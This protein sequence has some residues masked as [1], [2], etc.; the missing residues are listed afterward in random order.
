MFALI[1]NEF[2]KTWRSRRLVF[3]VFF[4]LLILISAGLYTFYVV[5][6]HRWAPPAQ[7]PWQATVRDQIQSERITVANLQHIKQQSGG[8]GRVAANNGPFARSEAESIDSGIK[9]AQQAISD[10]QYLLDNDVAPVQSNALAASTLFVLGSIIMFLLIRIFGWLASEMIAGERSDRT[11]AILL[12]RPAS[13]D[14]VLFAKTVSMFAVAL[15]V[16]VLTQLLAYGVFAFFL[17]SAGPPGG[18]IGLAIDGAKPLGPG[19]LV[20]M[21]AV[22]FTVM[23]LGAS[24]LAILAVEAMSL[25]ISVLTTRWAAIGITLAVLFAGPVVSGIVAIVIF[26]ITGSQSSSDFLNYVFFNLLNPVGSVAPAL[27]NAPSA[28][29]EGMGVMTHEVLA[30]AGWTVAFFVAAWALF[31]RR[32]E[33]G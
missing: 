22:V 21:P 10:N 25:L 7:T 24:M 19:N 8:S 1:S 5:R 12:S 20:Q 11:I 30:L 17:G 3:A 26:L 29:G 2:Q 23:A 18:T 6:E 28:A 13:R 4:G 31:H 14:Q 33:T 27:G 16:V 32:Q 15:G 9:Q